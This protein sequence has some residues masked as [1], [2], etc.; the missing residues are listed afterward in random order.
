MLAYLLCIIRPIELS[1]FRARVVQA[2][3]PVSRSPDRY[4][5]LFR[6]RTEDF[7]KRTIYSSIVPATQACRPDER[8]T[9]IA[10]AGTCFWYTVY[11]KRAARR[12][13]SSTRISVELTPSANY[14]LADKQDHC[15][16]AEEMLYDR[17]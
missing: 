10:S 5:G 14:P 9:S 11:F 15:N 2:T 3:P 8:G 16:S 17:S 12:I 7:R 6:F 1:G 4:S 13:L